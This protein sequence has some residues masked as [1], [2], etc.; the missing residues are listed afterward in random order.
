MSLLHNAKSYMVKNVTRL[1]NPVNRGLI[2][3]NRNPDCIFGKG[4]VLYKEF[5]SENCRAYD[6]LP[7][8]LNAVN[9][10]ISEVDHY[11]DLYRGRRIGSRA[12]FEDVIGFIDKDTVLANFDRF[13]SSA[14]NPTDYDT[15]TTGGTSGKPLTFISPKSRFVVELATMHSLWERA[16]YNF[17]VRA[18]IRNHRLAEGREAIINPLTREVIFDG[19]RSTNDYFETHTAPYGASLRFALST[20]TLPQPANLPPICIRMDGIPKGISVFLSGSE[21]ISDYQRELIQDRLGIRFDNWYGH[22]EKLILA[23]YCAGSDAYH[24]EPTYGYFELVDDSGRVIRELSS[25]R[26]CRHHLS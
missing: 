2:A 21:N 13:I 22:S 6:N 11:R 8:L 5:L 16:G 10:A 26:D 14:I 18:V 25:R 17:D 20:A 23:G 1:P 3:L 24:V 12:E 15:G 4:Y 19:F 9:R 7:Y